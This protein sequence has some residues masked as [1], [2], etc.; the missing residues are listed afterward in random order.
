M[1]NIPFAP[2]AISLSGPR[3]TLEPVDESHFQGLA[4]LAM[5]SDI[6]TWMLNRPPQNIPDFRDIFDDMIRLRADGSQMPFVVISNASGE[7]LGTSRL[8][9][10]RPKDRG[11]EIGYTW[12]G[13]ESRGTFVNLEAK[14]LLLTHSFEVLRANRVQL[15]TDARNARSRRAIEKIGAQFE[16]ILRSYQARF[17]GICR[18]TA[19]FSM[20]LADWPRDKVALELSLSE[21]G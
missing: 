6:W 15:K 14:Y 5:D 11:L 7:V 20:T 21:Q 3:I 1:S 8:F 12:Y 17:D 10:F 2:L 13:P 16:G 9:D 18:D 4:H 19:M